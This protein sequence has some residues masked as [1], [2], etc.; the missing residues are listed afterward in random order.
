MES[1]LVGRNLFLEGLTWRIGNGHSVRIWKDKWI[2]R[3]P[4][5]KILSNPTLLAP[6]STMDALINEKTK[7]W[8]ENL[9]KQLFSTEEVKLITSTPLS[10][11]GREDKEVWIKS[12]NGQFNV[13]S[14]YHLQRAILAGNEGSSSTDYAQRNVWSNI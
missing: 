3:P 2:C 8:K 10:I 9:I 4:S 11:C 5:N 13:K 7:C 1:L 12:K 14:A 6:I